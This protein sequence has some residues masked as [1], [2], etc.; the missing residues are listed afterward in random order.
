[1][2]PVRTEQRGENGIMRMVIAFA[3]AFVTMLIA[4]QI[5]NWEVGATVGGIVAIFIMPIA[6]AT[7]KTG[8]RTEPPNTNRRATD[9]HE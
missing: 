4:A 8:K 6:V 2:L 1:M 5:W 7:K 9:G 3:V